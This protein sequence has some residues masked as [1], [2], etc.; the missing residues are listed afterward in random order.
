MQAKWER[1]C[2]PSKLTDVLLVARDEAER[3]ALERSL[4]GSADPMTPA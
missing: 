2:E 4:G 1:S 3:A